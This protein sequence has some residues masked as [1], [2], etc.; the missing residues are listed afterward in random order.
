[1]GPKQI[2]DFTMLGTMV[3][4]VEAQRLGIINRVVPLEKLD[5]AALQ[6]AN[7]LLLKNPWALTRIKWLNYRQPSMNIN[8][9]V[10]L[11]TD[12][13]ALWMQLPDTQEGL[14][15]FLEKR[16]PNYEQFRGKVKDV[17]IK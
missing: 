10:Q 15:A 13:G 12:Q 1:M 11:G 7:I 14:S 8:D 9:A 6:M 4:A 16:K 2:N 17:L 3:P 5:D